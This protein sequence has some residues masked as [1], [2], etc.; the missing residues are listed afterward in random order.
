MSRTEGHKHSYDISCMPALGQRA[1]RSTIEPPML[2]EP[3]KGNSP[4][5]SKKPC[6]WNKA[7]TPFH[8]HRTDNFRQGNRSV[9]VLRTVLSSNEESHAQ[10]RSR[11]NPFAL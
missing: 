7:C 1:Q 8:E 5:P 4:S 6:I 2:P 3:P 11:K 10:L 9:Q